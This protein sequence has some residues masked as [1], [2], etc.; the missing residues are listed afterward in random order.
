MVREVSMAQPETAARR[1]T[2]TATLP[3]VFSANGQLPG[4]AAPT[5][6]NAD[7]PAVVLS[8]ET[9]RWK[10]L[11]Y[12]GRTFVFNRE[13][14]IRVLEED[15]GW[16]YESDDPELMGFGHTRAEAE[17]TFC[18]DFAIQ[19]DDLACEEDDSKLSRGARE[20][21]RG[22]LALVEARR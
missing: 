19:W 6:D 5:L 9:L 14:T 3:P 13:I 15:G 1:D 21:K 12:K 16:A 11:T 22:L 2:A 7:A 8:S 4:T 20:V 17:Y 10:E 18:L